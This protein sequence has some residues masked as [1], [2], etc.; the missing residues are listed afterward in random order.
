MGVK[1]LLLRLL[2]PSMAGRLRGWRVQRLIRTYTPRDVE[3]TYGTGPLRVRLADPLASGWYDHDWEELPEID[4]LRGRSLRAGAQ[5]FDIGAHQGVVA[6]MFAREVGASGFVLAVEPNP[7]NASIAAANR[8]LNH[9]SQIHVLEAAV[10]DRAG[11]IVFNEGLDGQIDDGF[12]TGGR[13][14]VTSTTLDELAE[15]FGMPDVVVIDVE[16]AECL[17]LSKARRVL[18][19]GADFAVE[20]HVNTGLEKLGGSV[21]RVLSYFPS[22]HFSVLAR[23][24][25]DSAFRPLEHDDPVT[26]DR[27]FLLARRKTGTNHA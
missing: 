20:V 11:T 25:G 24:E 26:R 17:A 22:T 8:A 9:M 19:S 2:P 27:F 14:T 10:S 4:A 3:H 6:L 13:M 12:G 21:E 18:D 1:R 16:G 7:H 15:R 23:A 5:V